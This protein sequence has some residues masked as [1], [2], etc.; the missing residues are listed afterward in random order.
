MLM[1]SIIM[2]DGMLKT[3]KFYEGGDKVEFFDHM[4]YKVINVEVSSK[5]KKTNDIKHKHIIPYFS[6]SKKHV[7]GHVRVVDNNNKSTKKFG[8]HIYS[9]PVTYRQNN[10]SKTEPYRLRSGRKIILTYNF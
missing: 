9:L 10:S 7:D 8:K 5:Y 6:R 1:I 2:N 4:K 3:K